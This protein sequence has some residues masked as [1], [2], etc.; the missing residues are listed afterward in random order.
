MSAELFRPFLPLGFFPS[1]PL[2]EAVRPSRFLILSFA[3]LN[4][5]SS[6]IQDR[7]VAGWSGPARIDAPH[8]Q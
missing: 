6:R 8:E 3:W 4:R 5:K 7:E 1:A 2:S